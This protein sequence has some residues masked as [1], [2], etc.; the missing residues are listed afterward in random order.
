MHVWSV[1]KMPAL[2]PAQWFIG[3]ALPYKGSRIRVDYSNNLAYN[4]LPGLLLE[5]AEMITEGQV[6]IHSTPAGK[7]P[8]GA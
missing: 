2:I 6:D 8:I 7:L 5:L 1:D 4:D 3:I